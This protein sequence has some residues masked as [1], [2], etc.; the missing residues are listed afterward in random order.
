MKKTFTLIFTIIGLNALLAQSDKETKLLDK[1]S[2]EACA[3]INKTEF[4]K[5][6]NV[7]ETEMKLGM[8]LLPALT[9]HSQ[10][11]KDVWGLNIA[12]QDDSRKVGEK[13]GAYMVFRC[14]KFKKLAL[15][16]AGND[17]FVKDLPDK[18]QSSG[19]AMNE[20]KGMLDKI[21]GTDVNSIFVKTDE[22]ETIKLLWLEKCEG[23]DL[24]ENFLASGKSNHYK[25]RYQV[26]SIFQPKTK[27]YQTV[28]VIT[29]IVEA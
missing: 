20:V 17:E 15:Q 4:S 25:I 27:T 18:S 1:L 19:T 22:G 5:K 11:I 13:L 21:E 16:L 3:E 14:D 10:E 29:G 7:S 8:A 23:S 2:N 6:D 28:K 24:L 26:M 12:N 9:N